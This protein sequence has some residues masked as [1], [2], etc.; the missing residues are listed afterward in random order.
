MGEV[1]DDAV[2]V[3]GVERAGL[4]ALRPRGVEHEVIDDELAAGTEKIGE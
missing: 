1:D 4:A 2:V 3:V